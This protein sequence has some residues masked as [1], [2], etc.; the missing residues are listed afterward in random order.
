MEAERIETLKNFHLIEELDIAVS[1]LKS[2]LGV[3]QQSAGGGRPRYFMFMLLLSTGL[4]RLMKVLLCI[5]SLDKE[6]KFLESHVLKHELGHD[7]IELKK[8][9]ESQ[10]FTKEALRREAM[11]EDLRF[12]QED[13]L[14]KEIISVLSDFAEE[15]RY[16]YL[17]GIN[18]PELDREWLDQR[19]SQIENMAI[20]EAK[21]RELIREERFREHIRLSTS[22]IVACLE[23]FLRALARTVTLSGLGKEAKSLGTA[24]WD[25]LMLKDDQ[26]GKTKYPVV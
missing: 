21:R 11:R 12:L 26:L 9:I 7:L 23:R 4:E 17:D 20:P 19:W 14:L 8:R 13:P 22:Q 16:L 25:F 10:G 18:Y 5:Y 6:G 15:D 3:L 1:T 24:V 2:G